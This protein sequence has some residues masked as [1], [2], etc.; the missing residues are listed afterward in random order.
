MFSSKLWCNAKSWLNLT[1]VWYLPLED[2][3]YQP[4]GLGFR[5]N[6]ANGLEIIHKVIKNISSFLKLLTIHNSFKAI[7]IGNELHVLQ[8]VLA[9]D[10]LVLD[11]L[12]CKM[13]FI[14]SSEAKSRKDAAFNMIYFYINKIS[15]K[16]LS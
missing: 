1:F 14:F 4:I 7:E 3:L 6:A 8:G 5:H 12:V 9:V 10:M 2:Y 13:E 16:S 15:C 11:M